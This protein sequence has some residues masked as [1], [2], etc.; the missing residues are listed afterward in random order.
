MVLKLSNSA[1]SKV[2]EVVACRYGVQ[3]SNH[4]NSRRIV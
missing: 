1:L 2:Q 3:K 4:Y